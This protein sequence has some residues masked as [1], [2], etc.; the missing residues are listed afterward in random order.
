MELGSRR[1]RP[2]DPAEYVFD[3]RPV[4]SKS[5]FDAAVERARA[6]LREA[7]KDGSRLEG[8]VWH[9]SRHTF[10]SR[11]AMA[12]ADPR[13][14]QELGGWRSLATVMSTPTW[15]RVT[16]W[17]PSRR[18]CVSRTFRNFTEPPAAHQP[19]PAKYGAP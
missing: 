17:R 7:G 16:G 3:P 15:R 19:V 2:G 11:L 18:S 6:V 9:S 14:I 13:T 5:F 12:G 10:A 4:Q 1:V 8:Y